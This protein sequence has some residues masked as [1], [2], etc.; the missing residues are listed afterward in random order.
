[1]S[2]IIKMTKKNLKDIDKPIAIISSIFFAFGLLNVLSASSETVARYNAPIFHFMQRHAFFLAIG[3]L[4]FLFVININT[5]KMYEI[6]VLAF[7]GAF[8]LNVLVVLIGQVH[9]GNLNWLPTGGQ[10]SEFAKPAIILLTA[11][12]FDKHYH[13]LKSPKIKLQ[14]NGKLIAIIL[15]ILFII[16]LVV[17]LFQ[18]DAGGGGL[19]GLISVCI[20]L[21]SPIKR[22][23][24]KTLI[25]GATVVGLFL[26]MYMAVNST[27]M[28]GP[29]Q[30]NRLTNF[31]DPCSDYENWGFQVCNS[32]IAIN[33]GGIFGVG[34][35]NSAQKH[36]YIPDAHTDMVFAIIAEEIGFVGSSL[37][38]IFM[39]YIL[40]R[41]LSIANNAANIRGRYIAL[42]FSFYMFFHI[43]INLGGL[44]AVIPLTGVPLPFFSYG[45]SFTISFITG[46]SLLQRVHI[47][48]VRKKVKIK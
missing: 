32:F 29:N 17:I 2:D 5:K 15:S 25:I 18:M 36:S 37:I 46:L 30:M 23:D 19:I 11:M 31:K 26:G 12:L 7:G 43:F 40:K 4:I 48:S 27:G 47:E 14:E 35:G 10:P 42:G 16:P 6:A 33:E 38:I 22:S 13:R 21:A 45:G 39:F 41:S 9:K 34:L 28:F 3:L 44:L 1:M 8:F 20:F 24:K